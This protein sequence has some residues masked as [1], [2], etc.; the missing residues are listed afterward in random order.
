MRKRKQIKTILFDIDGVLVSTD[1]PAIY[2]TFAVQIGLLPE[3]V[4]AY[5][6][7]SKE[8]LLLGEITPEQFWEDMRAA[9]GK[10]I[11]DPAKV[12]VNAGL[13]HRQ[14]NRGLLN[15]ITALRKTYTVGV[16]TNLTTTRLLIDNAQ[17]LYA[18]FDYAILS[19]C[20]RLKKPDA[21]FYRLALQRAAVLP[22]EAVFV[23]DTEENIRAAEAL[24]IK[25]SL[26]AYPDNTKLLAD[27]SALGVSVAV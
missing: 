18:H 25:G 21:A 5:H 4:A 16:L 26:F 6:E 19:C 15:I 20:E 17:D 2:A 7:I 24:G 23:D 22:E 8:A 13:K 3:I 12:W 27:L 11:A 9:G 14:V 10:P 1:F